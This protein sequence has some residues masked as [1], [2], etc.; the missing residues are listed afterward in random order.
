MPIGEDNARHLLRR[1]EFVDRTSRVDAIKD[2]SVG[3]A[4]DNI[5]ATAAGSAGQLDLGPG[6]NWQQGQ[7]SRSNS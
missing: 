1:T 3:Q 4:V 5:I 2:L 6:E 7:K